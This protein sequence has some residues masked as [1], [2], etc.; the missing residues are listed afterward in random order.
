[1]EFSQ[2]AIFML[3]TKYYV[4]LSD[5]CHLIEK[6]LS[7]HFQLDLVF[8]WSLYIFK[9]RQKAVG[10]EFKVVPPTWEIED[11]ASVRFMTSY[12]VYH[13]TLHIFKS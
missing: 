10:C 13:H 8:S 7:L 2:V 6:Q 9:R 5:C 4:F 11:N 3:E 1:M 12:W